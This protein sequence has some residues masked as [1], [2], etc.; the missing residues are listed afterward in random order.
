VKPYDFVARAC[1][2]RDP[3]L[4]LV[5]L[6]CQCF[7]PTRG[8][9]SLYIPD[10]RT[11]WVDISG[12]SRKLEIYPRHTVRKYGR[13]E[14]IASLV[15]SV[16]ALN[17]FFVIRDNAE[18]WLVYRRP[19]R[20]CKWWPCR[21]FNFVSSSI[22]RNWINSLINILLFLFNIIFIIYLILFLLFIYS[23]TWNKYSVIRSSTG[24]L[25]KCKNIIFHYVCLH[26]VYFIF[27]Y[28]IIL[29]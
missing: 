20:E 18:K 3:T 11:V 24:S 8:A 29:N 13:G 28:E 4:D 12:I 6:I 9:P 16:C 25:F 21:N 14:G 10:E 15:M 23:Q 5:R 17:A 7:A 26:C 19:R 2:A 1:L 27:V 22:L